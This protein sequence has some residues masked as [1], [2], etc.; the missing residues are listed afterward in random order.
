M[1][2]LSFTLNSLILSSLSEAMT[3]GPFDISFYSFSKYSQLNGI[4]FLHIKCQIQ[5]LPRWTKDVLSS[6]HW[7]GSLILN[8]Y[9]RYSSLKATRWNFMVFCKEGKKEDDEEEIMKTIFAHG[10]KLSVPTFGSEWSFIGHIPNS[11]KYRLIMEVLTQS[12]LQLCKQ[13]DIINGG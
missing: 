1:N 4:W 9:F 6:N 11:S 2:K 13:I 10:R 12:Q 3:K 7:V 8:F 5:I